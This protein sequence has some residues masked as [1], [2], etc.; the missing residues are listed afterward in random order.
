MVKLEWLRY[1]RRKGMPDAPGARPKGSWTGP[2]IE[3]D[4]NTLGK[5]TIAA[6]LAGGKRTERGD[7]NVIV[8]LARRDAS[9]VVLDVWR[10]RAD[11]PEVQRAFRSFAARY[12]GAA[13]FVEQAASGA[14]L[15]ASLQ[16]ELP[17]L[18]AVPTGQLG[19]TER[20]E[21]V[22]HFYEAGNI[23]FDEHA[24]YLDA[25]VTELTSY[26]N[27]PHDDFVDAMSLAIAKAGG[28]IDTRA[29]W[30]AATRALKAV[31][32]GGPIRRPS[33]PDQ[34]AEQPPHKTNADRLV[35][36]ESRET[37]GRKLAAHE[38]H[39]LKRLRER[40][41]LRAQQ[42]QGETDGPDPANSVAES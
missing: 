40:R 10:Q 13:M 7:Y 5:V 17:G 25:V 9:L 33:R 24:T 34:A 11:F 14:P 31:L 32:R 19:K 27:A 22:L 6:D 20:L 37:S 38:R 41:D 1:W 15:V 35:E 39:L 4:S 12:P 16:Q 23:H 42:P 21:A 30:Q 28:T 29:Q 3:V 8:A 36:L 2:S 26:P 18:V